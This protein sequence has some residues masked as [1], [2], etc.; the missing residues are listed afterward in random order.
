MSS[1]ELKTSEILRVR[2]MSAN[3]DVF[4]SR[5]ESY[6]VFTEK[7]KFTFYFILKTEKSSPSST[8]KI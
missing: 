1:S 3:F 5:D 2:S 7:S 8:V 6:L 4:N